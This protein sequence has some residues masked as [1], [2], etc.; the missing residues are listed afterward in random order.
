MG[1]M[2]VFNPLINAVFGPLLGLD[3]LLAVAL[4]SIVVALLISVI[5]KYTTDQNLMKRLK[6][7]MKELQAEAKA[8]RDHPEKAMAVQ[9]QMME[10][11]MKYM[12][13]SMRATMFT[14][15]PIIIIFGWMNAHFAFM[16]LHA[17]EEFTVSALFDAD[18]GTVALIPIE[19][20]EAVSEAKQTIGGRE[21]KWTL[22][23]LSPGEYLLQF[24][25]NEKTYTAPVSISNGERIYAP[26]FKNI[27]SDG[28]NQVRIN[29]QK[30][31]IL[32]WIG[33]GWL[34]SYILFSILF[35]SLFRKVMKIY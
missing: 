9:K 26:Q 29:Y 15:L 4:M 2:D 12:M 5:H 21:A 25:Y 7:E 17:G 31:P 28:F 6:D 19:G 14:L 33:W 3:P 13:Q 32:P 35:S 10:T 18:G 1:I 20:I 16:P 23:G 24:A 22:K 34:G 27:D 11:N 8:L 30:L